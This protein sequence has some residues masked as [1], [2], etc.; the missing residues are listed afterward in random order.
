LTCNEYHSFTGIGL[1]SEDV[2]ARF[3]PEER[4]SG[5][6]LEDILA[7]SYAEDIMAYIKRREKRVRGKVIYNG[8][9]RPTLLHQEI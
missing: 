4:I 5:L 2:L 1:K 6:K 9:V 8:V 3:K 7:S